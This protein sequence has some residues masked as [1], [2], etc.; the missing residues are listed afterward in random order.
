MIKVVKHGQKEFRGVCCRCGCEFIYELYD[1]QCNDYVICPD[2][3]DL[4]AWRH[5]NAIPLPQQISTVTPCVVNDWATIE[6]KLED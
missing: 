3:D 6:R 1:I 5:P 4:Y 2:C